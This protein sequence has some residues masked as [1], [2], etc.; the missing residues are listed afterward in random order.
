M[1][2]LKSLNPSPSRIIPPHPPP[3]GTHVARTKQTNRPIALPHDDAVIHKALAVSHGRVD[4]DIDAD[5]GVALLLVEVGAL[6]RL[7]DAVEAVDLQIGREGE[8]GLERVEPGAGV[9]FV[10][11]DFG[12][13]VRDAVGVVAEEEVAVPVVALGEEVGQAFRG[14]EVFLR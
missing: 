9:V 4:A 1:R 7:A 12:G 2:H 11:F 8:A 13:C 10:G 3:L 14:G 6:G 5:L